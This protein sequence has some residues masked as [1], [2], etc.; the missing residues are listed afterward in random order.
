MGLRSSYLDTLP[1]EDRITIQ[2]GPFAGGTTMQVSKLEHDLSKWYDRD[3]IE[4]TELMFSPAHDVEQVGDVGENLAA[5]S[6]MSEDITEQIS[7]HAREN[8]RVGHGQ[9]LAQARDEDFGVKILRRDF[10]S[11]EEPGLH[12]DSWQRGISDFLDIRRAM[13]GENVDVDL[14]DSEDGILGFISVT[15]RATFL[16]PPRSLRALPS[17]QPE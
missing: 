10:N 13:N 2:S 6:G 9:K 1:T 8:G 11:I 14:E 16:M 5:S 17:P 7:T 3:Q 12:F 15:N 4:R